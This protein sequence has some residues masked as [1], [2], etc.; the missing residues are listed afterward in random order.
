MRGARSLVILLLLAL[1]LGAYIYFVESKRDPSGSSEEKPKVFT[2]EAGT[3]DTLELAGSAG[4]VTKVEK[5]GTEWQIV[6]PVTAAADA[7]VIDSIAST[8]ASLENQNIVDEKPAA[9]A[10]FGLEPARFS[11]SF[12]PA[13]EST[14]RTL[15]VGNKTPV[16]TDLYAQVE[17][18]PRVFL[19]SASNEYTLDRKT[20]DLRDKTVL[21]IETADVDAVAIAPAS[22]PVVSLARSAGAWRLT[23]P[24]TARADWS[25]VDGVINRVA[26]VRMTG[27]EPIAGTEPSATELRK[28]GLDTPQ[29]TATFGAGSTKAVLALGAKKDDAAIFARDLSR[30]LV[31]TVEA[32]LIDDLKKTSDDLRTKEVFEFRSFSVTSISITRT[33]ATVAFAKSTSPAQGD[34]PPAETWTQTQPEARDVNQTGMTDL[35]NTLSSLRAS[36]FV[37]A[38]LASGEDTVIVAKFGEGTGTDERVTFRRSGDT[39]HAMRTDE[40]GAAVVPTAE[41]D[42]AL[43]QLKD[44][45]A[46]K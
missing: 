21:K 34:A 33:G 5:R 1:G 29:L 6:A 26:T 23:A 2:V 30:P 25:P 44:L 17:G 35:L 38:P 11:V 12:K 36:S 37:A 7:S 8:L 22:G 16:G 39:V 15:R 4:E 42:R 3:I 24:V 19:I 14:V 43:T 9:L 20:F 46:S 40:P 45:T 13:G 41:F 10:P 28:F 31:F 27:I 18:D 32:S